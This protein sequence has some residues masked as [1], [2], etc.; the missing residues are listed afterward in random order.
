MRDHRLG[1]EAAANT[2]R[3]EAEELGRGETEQRRTASGTLRNGAA[4]GL[5]PE[6]WSRRRS[7]IDMVGPV[8]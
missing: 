3:T 1:K 6:V 8:A 4:E 5:R 7:V 2:S